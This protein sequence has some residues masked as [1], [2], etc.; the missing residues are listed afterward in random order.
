MNPGPLQHESADEPAT[1]GEITVGALPNVPMSDHAAVGTMEAAG[2]AGTVAAAAG[3]GR[4]ET[5]DS[6]SMDDGMGDELE[7]SS[8]SY[9]ANIVADDRRWVKA[10]LDR[11]K[12]KPCDM[13]L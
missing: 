13:E 5:F 8:D 6:D 10:E 11:I 3:G 12:L 7:H 1:A 9:P 2:A 4:N